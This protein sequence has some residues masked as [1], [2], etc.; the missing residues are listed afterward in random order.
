MKSR[1]QSK[2]ARGGAGGRTKSTV[3]AGRGP[4]SAGQVARSRVNGN[5][6][7]RSANGQEAPEASE[8]ALSA[9]PAPQLT[10]ARKKELRAAAHGL[11]PLVHIGHNGLHAA[12]IDAV[13]R[14]LRDHELIKVR[15]HEPEDKRAMAATLATETRSALCGLI[16]HTVILF[17]PHSRTG[18]AKRARP[19][20]QVATDA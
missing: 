15:L 2:P 20:S 12:V 5:G 18:R 16:G 3:R 8:E 10:A 1:S 6:H 4:R 9:A 14:A 13:G 11:L 7:G 19:A 17:K